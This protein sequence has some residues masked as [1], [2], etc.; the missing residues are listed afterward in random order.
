MFFPYYWK[1]FW[2]KNVNS[3]NTKQSFIN[4][5][6]AMKA[7]FK[8]YGNICFNSFYI[9]YEEN[10]NV[11]HSVMT[12]L[13]TTQCYS[14]NRVNES[15]KIFPE[16]SLSAIISQKTSLGFPSFRWFFK[17]S[18]FFLDCPGFSWVLRTPSQCK[19]SVKVKQGINKNSSIERLRRLGQS[20]G[21]N[22]QCRLILFTSFKED[23]MRHR[24]I[25]LAS[26]A[27]SLFHVLD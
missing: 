16:F 18:K 2:C 8:I 21:N 25:Y 24:Q 1:D 10:I 3:W 11:S 22:Y 14:I 20:S 13:W 12:K 7:I 27:V 26:R 4:K 19:L 15:L 5:C 6:N 23:H 9:F 17:I